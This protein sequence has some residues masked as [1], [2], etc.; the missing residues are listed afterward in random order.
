MKPRFNVAPT[1]EVVAL[2][3]DA[4]GEASLMVWGM[5]GN[6]NAR[7]ETVA[8][9]PSFR[10]SLRT[11]RAVVF[12]D[13]YYEW[14][15]RHDGSQPYFIHRADDEPFAFAALWDATGCTII[16]TDAS[17]ELASIH[18]RMPVILSDEFR[19]AWLASVALESDAACA[20]LA[21]PLTDLVARPVSTAVNRVAN[22]SPVLIARAEP[23]EQPGLFS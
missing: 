22:D 6:I 8:V 3:N 13:G 23:P 18:D 4:G 19:E 2:R 20:L 21:S 5:G 1:Q 16:T 7:A 12:A 17:P 14:Q 15:K 11:K 9:K 10:E